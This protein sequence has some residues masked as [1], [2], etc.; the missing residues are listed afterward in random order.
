VHGNFGRNLPSVPVPPEKVAGLARN[1]RQ[2]FS[3]LGGR[4][5]PESVATFTENSN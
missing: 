4:F 2:D 5:N 3:G 1:R